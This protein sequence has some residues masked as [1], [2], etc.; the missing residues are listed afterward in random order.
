MN[1]GLNSLRVILS[2]TNFFNNLGIARIK[3]KT[4]FNRKSVSFKFC[5]IYVSLQNQDWQ[6]KV[7]NH[8]CAPQQTPNIHSPY[9]C[10]V[11]MQLQGNYSASQF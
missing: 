7:Y 9:P 6:G 8:A 11:I 2:R 1:L 3:P 4:T 10:T 5:S